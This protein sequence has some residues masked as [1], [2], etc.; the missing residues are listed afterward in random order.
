MATIGH[1]LVGL[2]LAGCTTVKARGGVMPHL[3]AAFIVLLAHAVDLV[4]WGAAVFL[5][6][7]AD[8]HFLTHAPFSTGVLVLLIWLVLRLCTKLRSP[9]AYLTVAAAVYSHLLLDAVPVRRFVA[10]AYTGQGTEGLSAFERSF[11]AEI[12]LFGLVF[13]LVALARAALRP[14]CPPKGRVAAY[15]LALAALAAAA[16]RLPAVWLPVYLASLTHAALLLRDRFNVRQL[17]GMTAILPVLAF[18]CVEA[19]ASHLTAKGLALRAAGRFREAIQ[20]HERV[21]RL[22]IRESDM[23]Q[24]F[25]VAIN[26][27]YLGQFDQA[28]AEFLDAIASDDTSPW[29]RIYLARLYG[30]PKSCSSG[31]YRPAEAKALYLAARSRE[32]DVNAIARIEKGLAELEDADAR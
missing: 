14:K 22:P 32:P 31:L 29:P 25:Y 15:V 20:V 8:R 30:N 6:P 16:S 17:W 11:V 7:S 9:V 24:H 1:T 19:L 27:Y 5:E 21:L 26:Y 12:C 3:W 23:W 4:E 18:V 2:S 13:V 10:L 28:E